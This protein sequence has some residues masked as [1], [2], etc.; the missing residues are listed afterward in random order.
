MWFCKRSGCLIR[1][2][3]IT[4]PFEPAQTA[5]SIPVPL[6]SCS[7]YSEWRGISQC[8]LH[9]LPIE[10]S[11]I[12]SGGLLFFK[13]VVE[14]ISILQARVVSKRVN[15]QSPASNFWE[16]DS[17]PLRSAHHDINVVREKPT[18]PLPG[19]FGRGIHHMANGEGMNPT[20][21]R[22]PPTGSPGTRSSVWETAPSTA[23]HGRDRVPT[24]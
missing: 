17:T 21:R 10:S 18:P 12:L 5:A 14:R 16:M 4:Q 20:I 9:E 1:I 22:N 2:M 7:E 15:L 3:I 6:R 13:T 11:V 8:Q 24:A 23:P 19:D